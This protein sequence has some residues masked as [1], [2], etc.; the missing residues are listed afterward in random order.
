MRVKLIYVTRKNVG[1]RFLKNLFCKRDKKY[2][3]R[4][5][6][7]FVDRVKINKKNDC[8]DWIGTKD[9][10]GYPILYAPHSIRAHRMSYT[11]FNDD[12]PESG[13]I[14]KHKCGNRKC[15][16][17]EHLQLGPYRLRLDDCKCQ[18]EW[19]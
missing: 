1:G 4:Q 9:L 19:A 8:W 18:S 7:M 14:V 15:V 12:S 3:K 16:N 2:T 11:M 10:K 17:P 6:E 5:Y 13:Y